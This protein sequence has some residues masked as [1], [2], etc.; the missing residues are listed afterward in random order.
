[1]PERQYVRLVAA[2]SDHHGSYGYLCDIDGVPTLSHAPIG[3]ELYH[4]SPP[5]DLL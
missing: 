1:M 4:Y 2:L 5:P 3:R